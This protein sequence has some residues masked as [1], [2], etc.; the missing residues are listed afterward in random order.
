M[1]KLLF[2]LIILL[3]SKYFP[4]FLNLFFQNNT[5]TLTLTVIINA[6]F[7]FLIL[8][9]DFINININFK[10]KNSRIIT[11]FFIG[12]FSCLGVLI[13][14][15]FFYYLIN[16]ININILNSIIFHFEKFIIFITGVFSISNNENI[17][18]SLNTPLF[19]VVFLIS[20][21]VLPLFEELIFRGTLFEVLK[22]F[23][24]LPIY[25]IIIITSL[26]FTF[27]HKITNIQH[28]FQLFIF[29]VIMSFIY[30]KR[31]LL[32]A[33]FAHYL[34]NFIFYFLIFFSIYKN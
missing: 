7:I 9:K 10:K 13:G 31:D 20:F 28:F 4:S 33:L 29:S 27:A 16:R 22:N 1:N 8:K 19:Q 11:S 6:F 18:N 25:I 12:I 2:I 32:T 14:S 21:F 26:L 3:T 17:L 5:L 30:I 15:Y 34:W 23:T 24:K